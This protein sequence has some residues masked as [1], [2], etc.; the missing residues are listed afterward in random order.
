MIL[1]ASE[2]WNADDSFK[3]HVKSVPS[4]KAEPIKYYHYYFHLL[5]SFKE[6]IISSHF[7]AKDI[8]AQKTK[9]QS[10]FS[11]SGLSYFQT[12]WFM[13]CWFLWL[14]G[15]LS[16]EPYWSQFLE[17]VPEGLKKINSSFI[18]EWQGN[19]GLLTVLRMRLATSCVNKS[20]FCYFLS[21][22]RC[23]CK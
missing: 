7:L 15:W 19:S 9:C 17:I 14:L 12:T 5:D 16:H 2:S 21:L 1:S 22:K 3:K 20:A 13:F 23:V 8:K 4:T 6:N 18:P 10:Q 11:N